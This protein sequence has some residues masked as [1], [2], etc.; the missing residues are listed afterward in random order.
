MRGRGQHT[1]SDSMEA[2][3]AEYNQLT[4]A[5]MA[6]VAAVLSR[7][8]QIW[9]ADFSACNALRP[10]TPRELEESQAEL[11]RIAGQRAKLMSKLRRGTRSNNND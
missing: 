9:P 6:E 2:T 5:L 10:A 1:E 3:R 4:D 7:R 11:N 8:G